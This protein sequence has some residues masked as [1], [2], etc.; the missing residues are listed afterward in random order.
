MSTNSNKRSELANLLRNLADFIEHHSDSELAFL[1][2]Q[3]TPLISKPLARKKYQKRPQAPKS[4]EYYDDIK[5]TLQGLSSREEGNELLLREDLKREGL[6]TLARSLQ[7]PV[8]RDDSVERLREKIIENLIGS[9]L[10]S[11]AIQGGG[12]I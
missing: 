8:Q 12:R 2:E 9:R 1:L 11:N 5:R 3:R 7:L 4:S 10:R 6:E